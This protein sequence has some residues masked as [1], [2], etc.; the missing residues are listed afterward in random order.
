VTPPSVWSEPH[1]GLRATILLCDASWDRGLPELN[2]C[3][4]AEFTTRCDAVGCRRAFARVVVVLAGLVSGG[5]ASAACGAWSEVTLVPQQPFEGARVAL[6]TAGIGVATWEG[7]EATRALLSAAPDALFV[8]SLGTPTSALRA[9]SDDGPHLYMGGAMGTALAAAIGVADKRPDRRVV[10][11]LGDGETLMGVNSLW[12]LAGIRP[13]NLLAAVLA[14]GHYTIT[15]GQRLGVP[16]RFA[17][18]ARALGLAAEVAR[19]GDEVE[20]AVGAL[21]RPA[22]LEIRYDEREWPGPSPFVDPPVVR[23]RFEAAAS[24]RR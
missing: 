17:A 7:L 9:A 6:G 8:A 21:A 24:A 3:G 20:R 15:G 18:V 1:L 19:S 14:D 2:R 5:W 4:A 11:L 22:L 12:A 10:A 13:G 16:G 23:H